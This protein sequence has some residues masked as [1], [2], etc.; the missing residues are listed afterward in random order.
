MERERGSV[1]PL[2]AAVVGVALL[3]LLGVARLGEVAVDRARAQAAADMAA[4]AG[5]FEQ[6]SGAADL[7][8]RNGGELIGYQ[9]STDSVS[10][11]VAVRGV[12]ARA[13]ARYEWVGEGVQGDERDR[14]PEAG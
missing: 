3:V 14:N 12:R 4:L 8:D 1:V 5:V 11:V 7:A 10:V 2:G 9:E 6:R 13:S